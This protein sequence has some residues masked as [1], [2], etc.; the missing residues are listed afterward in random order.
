M[1]AIGDDVF[2]AAIP[3]LNQRLIAREFSA[4]ELARAF[5][6]RLEQ[7]GPRYNALALPLA[8]QAIRR[9]EDVDKDLKR[10]RTHGPLQGVP[11]G[12]KDLISYKGRPTTWGAKPYVGQ[13]FDYNATVVDRLDAVGAVL[14]GKLAMVELAGGPSYRFASA[15]LTGPGLNPWDRT[16]WSGGSSSGSAA[17][18]AA[19]LVPYAL[20]SE[21]SGSILTPASYCG[22]TGLRPTY[23][24]VSRHGA[25]ALSWTL[26]KLGPLARSAEDCGLIL[27]VIAGKD[28]KDPGSAGKSFYYTPQYARPLKELK[29][30]YAPVDFGERAD[31]AARAA[32]AACLTVFKESGVQLVETAW[33]QF[34][35]GPVLATIL[36]SEA[37]S[38]FEPLITSGKV[39]ELAD[40]A[41]IAGLKASLEI[42]AKDYLKAQRVR[43]LIQDAFLQFFA[44]VD[45]VI[46][47]ARP[48]PASKIDQR[49]D[50]GGPGPAAATSATAGF[51]G[52]IPAGNLAG[53]P[54][55]SLPCGF[56][57][58]LPVGVQVMGPPFSENTLLAIGREFQ[59]KTD[60]HKRRPPMR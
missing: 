48:G 34:P 39:D 37:G 29:V 15:S 33:P 17:A 8:Q 49:L 32:F 2:F 52:I 23:G 59:S 41:Q 57:D 4:V 36:G 3:E 21:T 10:G 40:P 25:M 11:Y 26:D 7:L 24:L 53:L 6:N 38:I 1:P 30:G 19:G 13:V 31:P 14:T 56:A 27:Q 46:A 44:E 55:L 45:A 47:P 16:R 5:A 50:A 20:G 35:Y 12:V 54:A 28:S 22:V 18:V 51:Q 60:W 42:P 43:R 58:N 9:A